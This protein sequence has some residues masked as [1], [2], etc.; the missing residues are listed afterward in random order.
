MLGFYRF[1]ATKQAKQNQGL[2]R[3]HCIHLSHGEWLEVIVQPFGFVFKWLPSQRLH[4]EWPFWFVPWKEFFDSKNQ[5][6]I[7]CT[8]C[9]H[10]LLYSIPLDVPQLCQESNN[11]LLIL[12]E[13]SLINFH[14]PVL[15]TG[16]VDTPNIVLF[17]RSSTFGPL[18][19]WICLQVS[20]FFLQ[21]HSCSDCQE[22]FWLEVIEIQIMNLQ[23]FLDFDT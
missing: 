4:Q 15:V 20:L 5:G 18:F 9:Y 13:G 10:Y 7:L 6:E 11:Y 21:V 17:C 19:C 1:N 2:P 16:I 14:F 3:C 8:N 12:L 23:D 22:C